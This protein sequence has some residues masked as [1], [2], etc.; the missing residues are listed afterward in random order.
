MPLRYQ[1]RSRFMDVPAWGWGA[2]GARILALVYVSL[3]KRGHTTYRETLVYPVQDSQI[4]VPGG[5]S[6]I[7]D[8]VGFPEDKLS[9]SQQL[10]SDSRVLFALGRSIGH[11][12]TKVSRGSGIGTCGVPLG[13]RFWPTQIAEYSIE[14][15]RDSGVACHFFG[16]TRRL[17]DS[18]LD[19]SDS[20]FHL[21]GLLR[22]SVLRQ[23]SPNEDFSN[24]VCPPS[25]KGRR[26]VSAVMGLKGKF[27]CAPILLMCY[28]L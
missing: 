20:N 24:P 5:R 14:E 12:S 21:C 25:V 7:P 8:E 16:G 3:A 9:I 19:P 28:S 22:D 6:G 15:L 26:E 11:M 13:G 1:A 4:A 2:Q 17:P 27:T 23:E 18:S 10:L